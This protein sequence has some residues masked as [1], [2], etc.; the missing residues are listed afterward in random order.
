MSFLSWQHAFSACFHWFTEATASSN[1]KSRGVLKTFVNVTVK[2]LCW[3]LFL[4][5][6]Q[7][8]HLF[9]RTFANNCFFTALTPLI[10]TYSFYF[11]FSTFFLIIT[12]TT[13]NVCFWFKFKRLQRTK[14]GVS[15]SLKSLSLVLLSFFMFFFSVF[16]SFFSI[17]VVAANKKDF[18]NWLKCFCPHWH[19]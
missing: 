7:A 11:I 13:D 1:H 3:S 14:S 2:H 10:V 19:H 16:L 9:W 12:A 17:F 6:L 15:F 18:F 8:W 4:I 5:K